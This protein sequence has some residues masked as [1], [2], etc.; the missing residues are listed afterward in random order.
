MDDHAGS[1]WWNSGNVNCGC[2]YGCL[3]ILYE[4]GCSTRRCAC[5]KAQ[6]VYWSLLLLRVHKLSQPEYRREQF[7]R[8]WQW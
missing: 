2:K 3:T 7:V 4:V 6:L 8:W 1:S 5:Q